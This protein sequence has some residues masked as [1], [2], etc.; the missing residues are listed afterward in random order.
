MSE[1]K[2][3]KERIIID[4]K[5]QVLGRLAS[6][7]ALLLRGKQ[8]SNFLPNQ[9][10]KIIVV[11]RNVDKIKITGQK[12]SNKFYISHSGY[13]GGLKKRKLGEVFLKNPKWVFQHAVL[14]MLPKNKLRKKMIKNLI[15]E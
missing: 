4:A 8:K 9:E 6:R 11:V 2:K 10:P 5:D 13:P 7:V 12:M 3:E 15:F 14:G 1:T